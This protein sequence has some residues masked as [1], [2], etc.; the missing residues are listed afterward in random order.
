MQIGKA[1]SLTSLKKLKVGDD[2]YFPP[3]NKNEL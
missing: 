2:I 3:F 1:N